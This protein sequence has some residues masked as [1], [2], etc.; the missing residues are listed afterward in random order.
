M[1]QQALPRGA[2]SRRAVFGLLDKDGWTWAGLKATFWFL[3]IIFM[4]GV[5][6]NWAYFFTVSNTIQVGYNF[7]PIVNWC[8]AANEDLPCPAPS[9]AKL[10][11]QTS[12][13]E[14]AI[15]GAR[16][17]SAVYQSGSHVF[18]VGG[19]TSEGATAE[20]LVTTATVDA[21]E[22]LNG[23]ISAWERGPTLPEPRADAAIGTYVG[24]PYVLGG[25]DADGV[26]TDTVFKGVLDDGVLVDWELADGSDGTDPL[27]LPQPLSGASVVTGTSGFALLGGRDTNGEPTNG[28]HVAWVDPERNNGRLLAWE[29]LEGL[30]LPEARTDAVA[31]TVGN[32]IYIVGGEGP[33]GATA[34]VFRL[35]LDDRE[36]AT[37]E[38]GET[39]G[40]A[41][42]PAD[43]AL[44]EARTDAISLASSGAVYV[45][46][47]F[48]AAGEPQL[49]QYWAIPDTDTGN[50]SDG[51]Q[52]LEQTDL[53]VATA[54]APIAGLGPNVFI[55]G[56]Q[57]I[58]GPTDGSLRAG[59]SPEAPFYQL[60]I[61]GATLPGLAIQ[62][63]VGQQL[64]YI[65]AVTVGMVNFIL[66]IALGVAFSRPDSSKRVLSKLSGGRLKMPP[67]EQYRS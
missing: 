46:G 44:P 37:N 25:L 16:S 31:A 18:L 43:Q 63:E 49:S 4:L 8:P 22:Q 21:E 6:P 36:P 3:F 15:P 14:L 41:V 58:D 9:G 39:L 42:A 64:G 30:A 48:D 17:G 54:D 47:E 51:W 33:D 50:L 20:V 1:A 2:T 19:M 45:I 35:E 53:P 29:P 28:V 5:V 56:G 59:L 65:N 24:I 52:Q 13:E 7:V 55:F 23:N 38:V 32:F 11:W 61:A 27:T 66:L 10:P 57:T 62:G 67:E 34:T 26:P 12:P 40:W 60:G